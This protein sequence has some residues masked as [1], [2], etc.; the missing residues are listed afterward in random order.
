[1]VSDSGYTPAIDATL[2]GV[3][4]DIIAMSR[5][6]STITM[7]HPLFV[8]LAQGNINNH[9]NTSVKTVAAKFVTSTSGFR[10]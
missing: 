9:R 7:T 6:L 1:M 8:L 10:P 5:S 2:S 4:F 3:A